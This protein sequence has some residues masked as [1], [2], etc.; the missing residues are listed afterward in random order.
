MKTYIKK[1]FFYLALG[2]V[3]LFCLRLGYGYLAP[4]G[5]ISPGANVGSAGSGYSFG[6]GR[7][8][9]ATDKLSFDGGQGMPAKSV[10]QKYEKVASLLSKTNTFHD[11][12]KKVRDLIKTTPRS[13]LSRV[14][15]CPATNA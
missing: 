9:Y 10:D 6:D 7:K 4:T 15:V 1:G 14:P 13:S 5:D 11:D 3:V 2:F 12:E 8:N